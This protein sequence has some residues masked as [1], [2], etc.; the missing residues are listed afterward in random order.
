MG[1]KR[2]VAATTKDAMAQV[3]RDLGNDAVILSSR[4]LAN[5][6]IEILAARSSAVE[7]I[8]EDAR[9][10]AQPSVQIAPGV[11]RMGAPVESLHEYLQ[12]QRPA[13]PART[14]A[15]ARAAVSGGASMY[16]AVAAARDDTDA[17]DDWNT[18]SYD[19]SGWANSRFDPALM[20]PTRAPTRAPATISALDTRDSASASRSNASVRKP[21]AI[22]TWLPNDAR[23]REPAQSIR[24]AASATARPATT[25]AATEPAIFRRRP[26]RDVP[27]A[28][29][30]MQTY[31][32]AAPAAAMPGVTQ[33]AQPPAQRPAQQPAY[34]PAHHADAGQVT[35]RAQH[36]PGVHASIH[37]GIHPGIQPGDRPG[38]ARVDHLS[39]QL[40]N[41]RLGK[42]RLGNQ[43]VDPQW[44]LPGNPARGPISLVAGPAHIGQT[45]HALAAALPATAQAAV[46]APMPSI[47]QVVAEPAAQSVAQIAVQQ[48]EAPAMTPASTPITVVPA[49]RSAAPMLPQTEIRLPAPEPASVNAQLMA[50]LA[51]LRASLQQ[52]LNS[53]SS[54]VAATDSMRRNP[55]QTRVMTRL[56][57]S[58]FSVDVARKIALNTPDLADAE[59]ADNWMQEVVAHNLRVAGADD[60][61]VERGGVYALVG[62]T[63]VGKTT[64]VA[65]L[66]ARFA[67]KYGAAALGLITLDAYRVAAHEQLRTY[68]RILGTPVHL[69]Q[70]GATLRELLASMK[71]KRLVLID[72][73]GVGP[74]DERLG[75]MLG[76]LTQA[77]QG[78]Q[79]IQPVLLINAAS[80]AE[81]LDDTAR[82]WRAQDAVGA[83]L[84]KLDEAARIGGALDCALRYKLRLLGLTNGQRVPEDLHQPNARLLAH[85]ALKP[86]SQLFELAIEEGAALAHGAT[87]AR[88]ATHA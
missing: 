26:S 76:V 8:V 49:A 7:A 75:E 9:R 69:A 55:L 73:C 28:G 36:Q 23:A 60:N 82:A 33:S 17:V 45:H 47:A 83:I 6:H 46:P 88:S 71:N 21:P 59:A 68:G 61:L 18:G 78:E 25:S 74:R 5:G 11:R 86:S 38:I 13:K 66:A 64:T 37:P 48:A 42:E 3:R 16:S 72:T 12:R 85:L 63:G 40:D 80:H 87:A 53:L 35:G 44:N 51:S 56:L 24:S 20:A 34:A 81:T 79:R 30:A 15:A 54:T 29:P 50:E 31:A 4:R 62:P 2:F 14:A 1:F 39:N 58:G 67:V 27:A 84:T 65:K 57:T 70:D 10:P 19:D 52:Q 41:E 77:G 22:D 32:P 43:P